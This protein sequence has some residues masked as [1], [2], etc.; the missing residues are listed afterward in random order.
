[1]TEASELFRGAAPYYA[2]HRLGYPKDLF[3]SLVRVCRLADKSRAID[4]GS[5]TGQISIP[6]A[7]SIADVLSVDPNDEMIEEGRQMARTEGVENIRFV[8]SRSEDL[9]EPASLFHI[10]TIASSFHWMERETVLAKL[11]QMV[12]PDGCVAIIERERYGSDP[13]GWTTAMWNDMR[14]FWGGSFPAGPGTTR[15][16]TVSHRQMLRASAFSEITELRHYYQHE[17]NIDD[18]IG[19]LYSTSAGAP[20]TLGPRRGAF[21]TRMR[22]FLLSY[23][24]SGRFVEQ[25]YITTLLGY[26]PSSATRP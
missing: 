10:A 12:E 17:W 20:G 25:G 22:R 9:N 16:M 8:I 2:R 6:L 1:M 3:R 7:R 24:P 5:G 14:D 18:L 11:C 23:S 19:Y 15:Q 4:L 13:D 26:R 21:T